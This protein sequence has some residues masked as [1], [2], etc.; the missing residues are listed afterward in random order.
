MNIVLLL[1]FFVL[2]AAYADARGFATQQWATMNLQT[3]TYLEP[4]TSC[5]IAKET[6]LV[7]RWSNPFD[8]CILDGKLAGYQPGVSAISLIA[9]PDEIKVGNFINLR[10]P[11]TAV[12]VKV[13]FKGTGLPDNI[14]VGLVFPDDSK[15]Y[16]AVSLTSASPQIVDLTDQVADWN[17]STM[18]D[19]LARSRIYT[20][21][22]TT[23]AEYYIDRMRLKV[24]GATPC[25]DMDG[26]GYG[27]CDEDGD[28]CNIVNGCT[29]DGHDCNDENASIN[30]GAAE[31][32]SDNWDNNCNT[33]TDC[34]DPNCAGSIGTNGFVCC[35][36]VGDCGNDDCVQESCITAG[37]VNYCYY[38]QTEDSFTIICNP[39]EQY[40]RCNYINRTMCN[41]TECSTAGPV[42][43]QGFCD[44]EGGDCKTAD[45]SSNVCSTCI[46][47]QTSGLPWTWNPANHQDAGKSFNANLF[48]SDGFACNETGGS[49]F[50]ASGAVNHKPAMAFGNCCGD[51]ANEFYKPDYYGAECTNNVN[52]CVWA[53]GNAQQSNSGNRNWWCYLHEWQNCTALS[54]YGQTYGSACCTGF[55][56]ELNSTARANGEDYYSC[57]DGIDND[58]DGLIDCNDPDCQA[59]PAFLQGYV[60]DAANNGVKDAKVEVR[61]LNTLQLVS[62]AYTNTQGFYNA[63]NIT[64]TCTSY[65]II[66][67][68]GEYKAT[69]ADNFFIYAGQNNFNATIIIGG[70]CQDDCTYD[71]DDRCHAACN[72]SITGC[73]FY[74][75]E[76][77]NICDTQKLGFV[78]DYN[79]SHSI[80]CCE[81]NPISNSEK[82]EAIVQCQ[83]SDIV[84]VTKL[85]RYQGKPVKVI[86]AVCG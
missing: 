75:K 54:Q 32:C 44:R 35:Q 12:K 17:T 45:E 19:Y 13:W 66:V 29:Y 84:K 38:L 61:T 18:K 4:L 42:G 59:M 80:T 55:G 10:G 68:K 78:K 48:N 21:T 71:S 57:G 24:I 3:N 28:G 60:K 14:R 47:D 74:S 82:K 70:I 43:S 9:K 58:C 77:I 23:D 16:K 50:N 25:D 51:D 37:P 27:V 20:R 53:D 56:W 62:S 11:V 65:V 30:P 73:M 33:L 83:T 2:F 67:S 31:I 79:S 46:A 72:G 69:A 7:D 63:T 64:P 81:N 15:I 5:A 39:T 40:K 41:Q 1:P 6:N 76:A 36:A 26:D 86:I 52:D 85:A 22:G 49:C 34:N 8:V